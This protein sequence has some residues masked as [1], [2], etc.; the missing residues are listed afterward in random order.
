MEKCNNPKCDCNPCNCN[1]DGG[2]CVCGL[3]EY[4]KTTIENLTLDLAAAKRQAEENLNLAKYQKAEFENYKKRERGNHESS[5]NDGK[6][7]AIM[8]M[9]PV[10]DALSEAAK[11]VKDENRE[12]I[13]MLQRK[14]EGILASFGVT[15]IDAK[16]GDKFD[17]HVHNSVAV[18]KSEK[19]PSGIILSVWQ[20]GYKINGKV[21]RATSVKVNE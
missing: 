1:H 21:L 16:A 18:G 6:A 5:F 2:V 9:L 3:D 12:G 17:P 13:E 7:F 19:H 8:N 15:E 20:K 10:F 4:E 14:F 11:L